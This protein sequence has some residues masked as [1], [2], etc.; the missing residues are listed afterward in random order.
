MPR[1]TFVLAFL[2]A[3]IGR[4]LTIRAGY[5]A[6][7]RDGIGRRPVCRSALVVALRLLSILASLQDRAQ[8]SAM[9]RKRA[10]S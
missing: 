2:L 9:Y 8:M 5:V 4:E 1:W 6:C 7:S 10:I 3:A